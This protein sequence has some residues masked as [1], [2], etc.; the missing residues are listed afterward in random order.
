[1]LFLFSLLL[2]LA[3]SQLDISITVTS[4][5]PLNLNFTVINP[6]STSQ[7]F[8][9]WGTPLEGIWAD[10]F[11]I[12]DADNNKVSYIGMLVRRGD[13]PIEEEYVTVEGASSVS[14]MVNL[15]DNYEFLTEGKYMVKVALPAYADALLQTPNEVI[16]NL[17][18]VPERTPLAKPLAWTN[19]QSNQISIGNSA[20]SSSATVS[21]RAYTCLNQGCD[22]QYNRWFGS[23]NANNWNFVSVGFRN[24]DNRLNNYAF[25]G[26]CNP[27][28]C[29]SNV[30]GY[31]YPTD[32][33][34][35]VYLCA[36][37]WSRAN[38]RVNTIVHEM[39]HF[40]S[41]A[42]TQDYTYGQSNCLALARNNPTQASHNADNVCYFAGEV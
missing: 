28:G 6:L 7:T 18:T 40:R 26:Y 15:G 32:S 33:T 38:E 17:P 5:N 25:N 8:L 39:S 12:R 3:F 22:S 31:V 13:V 29:G 24:I 19:C 21:G 14:A 34:Y 42:G 10:I 27:A 23:Y 1:M 11:D 41:L 4:Q 36:L 35:T 2:S 16:F 37:F 20:V 30:F 9:R